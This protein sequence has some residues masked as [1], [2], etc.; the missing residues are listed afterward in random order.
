MASGEKMESWK[1]DLVPLSADLEANKQ[2]RSAPRV[3]I[4]DDNRYACTALARLLQRR[5]YAADTAV[6]GAAALELVARTAY[7]LVI[8]DFRLPDMTGAD[9]LRAAR[10]LHPE[11]PAIIVTACTSI[12]FVFLALDVGAHTVLA[13]PFHVDELFRVVDQLTAP[14]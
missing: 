9:V 14:A 7:S 5:N 2:L 1:P 3:L 8:L 4:V 12:D 13:K 6:D 10:A 11:L